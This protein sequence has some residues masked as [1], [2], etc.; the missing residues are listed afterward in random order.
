MIN[1]ENRGEIIIATFAV[2]KINALITEE[3]TDEFSALFVKPHVKLIIDFSGVK[4]ID[5]SGFGCLLSIMRI[6]SNNYGTMKVVIT[7][8]MLLSLFKTLFLHTVFEIYDSVD[9]CIAAF[10]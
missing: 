5:S 8:P 2:E 3:L 1:V 4:Y 7:D 10:R 6:A 9:S